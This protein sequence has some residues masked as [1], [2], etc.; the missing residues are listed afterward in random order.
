MLREEGKKGNIV[1]DFFQISKVKVLSIQLL[2]R[3]QSMK[4][5]LRFHFQ[6]EHQHR[7]TTSSLV[8]QRIGRETVQK[9][10]SSRTERNYNKN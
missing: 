3:S 1:D 8:Q 2:K 9:G 4:L 6:R 5:S 10:L 7:G